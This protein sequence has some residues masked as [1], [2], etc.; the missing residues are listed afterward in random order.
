MLPSDIYSCLLVAPLMFVRVFLC[1]IVKKA[2]RWS[3]IK[4]HVSVICQRGCRDVMRGWNHA[5][6]RLLLHFLFCVGMR[7]WKRHSRDAQSNYGRWTWPLGR[8]PRV[9]A[10]DYAGGSQLAGAWRW[11]S[12]WDGVACLLQIPPDFVVDSTGLLQSN[13]TAGRICHTCWNLFW[14]ALI[15]WFLPPQETNVWLPT[16]TLFVSVFFSHLSALCAVFWTA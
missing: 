9:G 8:M 10:G 14:P 12:G 2:L 11:Y 1:S 16:T 15:Q 5:D 3:D 6:L 7:Y 13:A 4:I